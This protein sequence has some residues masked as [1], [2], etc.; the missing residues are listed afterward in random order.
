MESMCI[1]G[2]DNGEEEVRQGVEAE[3]LERMLVGGNV[4]DPV[5]VPDVFA[6]EL[7]ATATTAAE[8][9]EVAAVVAEVVEEVEEVAGDFEG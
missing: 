7:A 1:E 4:E 3:D 9:V 6:E 5:A 8:T 2:D